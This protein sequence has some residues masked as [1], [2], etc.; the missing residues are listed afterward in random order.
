MQE[1]EPVPVA[2][3]MRVFLRKTLSDADDPLPVRL[4]TRN[5]TA[6][7]LE[8]SEV[9]VTVG[10]YTYYLEDLRWDLTPGETRNVDI[11]LLVPPTSAPL[12]LKIAAVSGQVR[13][14][15]EPGNQLA[16]RVAWSLNRA[17]S[18]KRSAAPPLNVFLSRSLSEEDRNVGEEVVRALL[19]WLLHPSTVGVPERVSDNRVAERVRDQIAASDGVIIIAT[20]RYIDTAGRVHTFEYAHAEAAVAFAKEKP[21]LI[22]RPQGCRLTSFLKALEDGGHCSIVDVTEADFADPS[23]LLVKLQ[24]GLHWFRSLAR[25]TRKKNQWHK[26]SRWL[27]GGTILALGALG[28]YYIGKGGGVGSA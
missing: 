2:P 14:L 7:P 15:V 3:T 28:G 18:A 20:P 10:P 17:L 12:D 25:A 6:Y 1:R 26:A 8:V 23:D 13:P 19:R 24:M 16:R 11:E 22:V 9:A 4:Q 5:A 27:A 21:I